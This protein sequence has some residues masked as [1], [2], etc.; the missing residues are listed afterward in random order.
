MLASCSGTSI[1]GQ[2]AAST[3]YCLVNCHQVIGKHPNKGNL[4]QYFCQYDYTESD[5]YNKLTKLLVCPINR[6]SSHLDTL[7]FKNNCFKVN[8]HHCG[9]FNEVNINSLIKQ[10]II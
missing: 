7:V 5:C 10:N 2:W 1:G 4:I 9:N 3:W 8:H 6:Y